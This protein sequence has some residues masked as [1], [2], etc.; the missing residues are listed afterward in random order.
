METV[1]VEEKKKKS[2]E[3]Q[4]QKSLKEHQSMKIRKLQKKEKRR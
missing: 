3:V 2:Y 1:K 4:E